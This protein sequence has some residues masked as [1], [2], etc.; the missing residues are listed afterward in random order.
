MFLVV[1]SGKCDETDNPCQTSSDFG[2]K[3]PILENG[4]PSFTDY[5]E[6]IISEV[7]CDYERKTCPDDGFF[8]G[9]ECI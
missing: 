6:C 5:I 2:L 8:A 4:Q 1:V 3:Y 7:K 9:N